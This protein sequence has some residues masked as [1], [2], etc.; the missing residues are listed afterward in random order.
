MI[1]IIQHGEAEPP[2]SISEYLETRNLPYTVLR[3]FDD[4]P[5]PAIPPS[6]LIILGGQ[7][8]ANDEAV[9][10]FLAQEK[11]LIQKA[12]GRQSTVFG[13]CLGAQLIAASCGKRVFPHIRE[14]GWSTVHG[15]TAAWQKI[16]PE[17]FEVFQWHNDT[18]DL[19]DGAQLLAQNSTITNQAF[20]IGTALGVQFHP[21]VTQPVIREWA[22]DLR[23]DEQTAITADFELRVTT[24]RRFCFALM[25]AFLLDWK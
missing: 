12:I 23:G 22:K 5:L 6:R 25:D 10:P 19:P 16:F 24:T 9:Y 14:M 13:I 15:T 3:T 17:S 8:S 11:Q 21:E 4:D 1:T 2:G 20:S 7:M 18:F